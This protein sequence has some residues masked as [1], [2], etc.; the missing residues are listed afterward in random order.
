MDN[1]ELK[2][3]FMAMVKDGAVA[4]FASDKEVRPALLIVKQ[5]AAGEKTLV[6]VALS[7]LMNPDGKD[8]VAKLIQDA[9]MSSPFVA[10]IT[11]SRMVK[12]ECKP[13]QKEEVLADSVSPSEDP[14]RME[15]VSVMFYFGLESVMLWAEIIRPEKGDPFLS[16]WV[17][18]NYVGMQ[19]RFARPPP[20]WS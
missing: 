18:P 8:L 3:N 14:D 6:A 12:K 16:N 4:N 15:I 13:E 17:E 1:D 19:G 5:N 7:A 9:R 2:Q 11:E 20:S 10:L